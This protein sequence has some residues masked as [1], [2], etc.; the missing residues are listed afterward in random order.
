MP[1]VA[2][3]FNNKYFNLITVKPKEKQSVK[4]TKSE[5]SKKVDLINFKIINVEN[6]KS[7]PLVIKSKNVE[8]RKNI[9]ETVETQISQNYEKFKKS[10]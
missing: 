7:G 6:R 5:L 9:K 10:Y 4:R 3:K 2:K 8:E 1:Y